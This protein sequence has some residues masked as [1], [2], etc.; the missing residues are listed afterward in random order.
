MKLN[1]KQERL[2]QFVKE[3]HGDQA[4]KYDGKPYWFH[5]YNVASKAY[6]NDISYGVEIGLCHDLFEDTE[7]NYQSLLEFLLGNKYEFDEAVFI[8]E[9]VRDLTDRF[10][11][12][13]YPD[14]NRAYRKKMEAVRLGDV[15]EVSQSVKFCDLIDNLESPCLHDKKFAR[16]YLAEKEIMLD[17]MYDGNT[18]L[19][20]ECINLLNKEKINLG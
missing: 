18:R 4:R 6:M 15:H 9:R 20:H 3:Q 10:T 7:C 11:K 13:D 19:R 2:L 1:I 12:E 14:Y 5:L 17:N 8:C 16:V